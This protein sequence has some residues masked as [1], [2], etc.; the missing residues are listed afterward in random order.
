MAGCGTLLDT[1]RIFLSN[2]RQHPFGGPDRWR[3]AVRFWIRTG[4]SS[5]TYA[6]T[7]LADPTVGGVRY[8]SGYAPDFP[9]QRTPAP[10]WR[11]RPLAG[12]GTLLDTHRIFLSNVRQHPFGGPDRWRG[13]VRFWIR[14]GFSSATYASTHLADPTVGGVRYASGYAPDFPQQRTPAPFWRTR[15]L[16]GCGTLLDTHRIFLS[17][18]RQHP[19]GG[20]DRWRGAVRFWIRTG[21]SSATYASTHLAD[22]TVGGVRYPIYTG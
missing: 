4:F 10:I 6:S 11:T 20:P 3:G 13:A 1:H 9:Q 21:F 7:H 17:N 18:V 15:P 5:A 16:A 12:C 8:A 2:V 14:T 22:P 19:F